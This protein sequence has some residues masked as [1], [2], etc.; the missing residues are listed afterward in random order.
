MK[1]VFLSISAIATLAVLIGA[2]VAIA[3]PNNNNSAKLRSAVTAE[4][5][6]DHLE[7]FDAFAAA[8]NGNRLSGTSGYDVAAAYVAD[9]ARAAGYD[10]TLQEF[11]FLFVGD[12]TAPVLSQVAPTPTA[13]VNGV[14][15]QTMTYSGSGDVTASLVA[16]DLQIPPAGNSTSG[17][18]AADFGGFPAGAIALVQRGTCSFR[19]KVTNATAAG[20]SAVIVMNEGN[21]PARSVLVN[22][23]LSPP[24]TLAAIP[25]VGT[26][27]ALGD[28]LRNGVTS[29][30][31]GRTM[32]VRVDMI[33]ENRPTTNVIAETPAGDPGNV[34]VVGAHLDSISTTAAMND[35]G[36]GS[37]AILEIAE[38]MAKVKP[39]N[40]VRFI[41]FG[42]EEFGLLG[43]TFY[44]NNLTAAERES[45][46][47][48]LNFDML[49]SPN[50]VRF[51]Y[52]GDNS[53]FP[54]GP[55]NLAGSPGSGIVESVFNDYFAAQGLASA[56]VGLGGNTDYRPFL[57]AGIPIGGLFTGGG[58]IKTAAEAAAFGG[59]AGEAY[60]ACNHLPCDDLDNINKV[61]LGEMSDAAAH[62]IITFAQ[63]TAI[64]NG[65]KGKG[66]FNTIEQIEMQAA[67]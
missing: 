29:G 46:A 37:A 15:F 20:A 28:A 6:F 64:L 5:V 4:G 53:T 3:D 51:V 19:A 21:T 47:L 55:G 10:V 52:D 63:S 40:K 2:S 25:A 24:A 18:E 43:S 9:K 16:V 45:I 30:S 1:R 60:D 41:W 39:R 14:D 32:R 36:S 50:Y 22:G 31:T 44:V 66:N 42:A 26:T 54:A 61:A 34:V 56:P 7:A 58:G 11:Q 12:R 48:M 8:N 49:G 57:V 33:A 27:F 59:T 13:Y 23:T 35:D 38:Q 67:Q 65:V 17:C 62:A